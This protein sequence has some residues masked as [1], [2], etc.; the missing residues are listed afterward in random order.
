LPDGMFTDYATTDI[1]DYHSVVDAPRHPDAQKLL[2]FWQARPADGIVMGRDIPSREIARLLSYII[3]TEPTEDRTDMR[4]RLA[5]ASLLKRFG[6]DIKDL[7]FSELFSP[8]D[9]RDHLEKGL[10][11]IETDQAVILD[12]RLVAG[13]VEKL[14]LEAVLL[15]IVASDRRKKLVLAGIFYFD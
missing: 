8:E 15:P 3:I 5:G 14:H 12:S 1:R 2:A 11:A 4:V 9:F 6:R 13:T 10:T 7:M